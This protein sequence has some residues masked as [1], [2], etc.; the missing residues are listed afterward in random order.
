[1]KKLEST[2]RIPVDSVLRVYKKGFGYSRLTI[3]DN[4]DRYMAT[5]S[6]EDFYNS[7]PDGSS[8]EAYLW[9]EDVASYEFSCT[10]TGRITQGERILFLSHT[11]E[12]RRNEERLCLTA[13]VSVPFQFFIFNS[14][15]I[16]K[17]FTSEEIKFH[18]GL[19][20]EMSDREMVFT[21]TDNL[22]AVSL[23]YGHIHVFDEDVEIV[24]KYEER[25]E[26]TYLVRLTGM[27]ERDRGKVLDYIFSV[28]RE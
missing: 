15:K 5:L 28:Y 9:V 1:M 19:I 4:N 16:E 17:S 3:I 8:I 6:D 11:E 26:G 25:G 13:Q 27:S 21:C 10:I 2:K 23:L 20:T 18:T 12:I 14:K 24:G 22:S 7:I